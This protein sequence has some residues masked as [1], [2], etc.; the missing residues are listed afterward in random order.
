MRILR[1]NYYSVIAYMPYVCTSRDIVCAS[2]HRTFTELLTTSVRCLCALLQSDQ[3]MSK[4]KTHG[5]L[6]VIICVLQIY[7]TLYQ[8]QCI[9]IG[10][11]VYIVVARITSLVTVFAH[12]AIDIMICQGLDQLR[13]DYSH[14]FHNAFW[15]ILFLKMVLI[16]VCVF[17]M[18]VPMYKKLYAPNRYVYQPHVFN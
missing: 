10:F 14:L 2:Y 12:T 9:Y 8:R 7:F 11:D 5:D 16:Y 3:I 1:D 15:W 6:Y 18:L 13:H 17:F 4:V